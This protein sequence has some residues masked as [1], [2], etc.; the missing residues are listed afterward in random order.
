[1]WSPGS[2]RYPHLYLHNSYR[3][4]GC[5]TMSVEMLEG[6]LLPL[7]LGFQGPYFAFLELFR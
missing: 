7:E 5:W 3:C 6:F 1:M 2:V 4:L